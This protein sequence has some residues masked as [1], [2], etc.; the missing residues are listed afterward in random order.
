MGGTWPAR[1]LWWPRRLGRRTWLG[2]LWAPRWLRTLAGVRGMVL[3]LLSLRPRRLWMR[4]WAGGRS[5]WPLAV[6]W[7]A[8]YG[9]RRAHRCASLRAR[10]ISA[11]IHLVKGLLLLLVLMLLHGLY[12]GGMLPLLHCLLNMLLLELL[13]NMRWYPGVHHVHRDVRTHGHT[14]LGMRVVCAKL[15]LLLLLLLLVLYHACMLHGFLLLQELRV[16][17]R[18]CGYLLLLV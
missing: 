15:L 14:A 5:S 6:R 8:R 18:Q 17:V 2:G 3:A 11:R 13:L 10:L 7:T 1:R 9:R 4:L 16:V 12:V